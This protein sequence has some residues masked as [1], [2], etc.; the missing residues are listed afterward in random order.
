[1]LPEQLAVEIAKHLPQPGEEFS[2][3]QAQ[4]WCRVAETFTDHQLGRFIHI[5]RTLELPISL[6]LRDMVLAKLKEEANVQ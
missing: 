5:A 4:F 3:P 1:M 6:M 2:L